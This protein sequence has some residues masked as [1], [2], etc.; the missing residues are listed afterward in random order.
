MGFHINVYNMPRINDYKHAKEIFNSKTVVRGENQSVRRLGDRYEKEKWL[1]QEI[2]DGIEVYI[3]GY[4]DTDLV[5][6]YP[7][8]KEITLG[9]YPS[10]S[11]DYFV[12][13]I[14]GISLQPFE[15]KA[16]VPAPFTRSPL[17]K[18]NHIEC[19]IYLHGDYYYM[20]ARDWYSITY[21][22]APM[23]PEQFEKP[24]KYRFDA[25]QMRE[26][27]KPYKDT[28]KYIDTILKLND[29]TGMET[30]KEMGDKIDAYGDDKLEMLRDDNNR[31]LA[32][33]Y[34]CKRTQRWQYSYQSNPVPRVN[35]GQIKRYVDKMIKLEN[36]QVL[37]EVN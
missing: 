21:D 19:R 20:N 18:N 34:L 14:G 1:R 2:L 35:I 4:Y 23:Y 26:L 27:R 13:Y 30:D 31:Y 33:Y 10:T 5:A 29:N 32:M 9:G 28:I 17:V 16:Y 22:N 25:S 3:A 37:V 11:T 36:P 7:T 8:H 6:F 12:S 15:H 24:V